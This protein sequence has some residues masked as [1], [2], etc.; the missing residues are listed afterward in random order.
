MDI[1]NWNDH[2]ESDK[3]TSSNKKRRTRCERKGGKNKRKKKRE[4]KEQERR[5]AEGKE[6]ENKGV[7]L[8]KA[9]RE[10]KVKVE[11]QEKYEWSKFTY[12]DILN[13]DAWAKE[14]KNVNFDE[15][16]RIATIMATKKAKKEYLS[17]IHI[18]EP[19]RPY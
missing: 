4:K 11:A 19:T 1:E 8:I 18:S 10:R 12:Q 14:E 9:I 2:S 7:K 3:G 13:I 5:K 16:C 6:R 15:A 17:L